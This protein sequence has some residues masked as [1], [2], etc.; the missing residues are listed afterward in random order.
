[1][2]ISASEWEKYYQR[3][4]KLEIGDGFKTTSFPGPNERTFRKKVSEYAIRM[5]KQ[6]TVERIELEECWW[7]FIV[8]RV[9]RDAELP[10]DRL[11]VGSWF[12]VPV[13]TLSF[14]TVRGRVKMF[15]S[16]SERNDKK[17]WQFKVYKHRGNVY[18][19]RVV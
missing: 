18:V 4:S 7:A 1:M 14:D 17:P 5:R 11:K 8:Y 6:F 3:L 16:I 10:F 9:N 19:Q 2:S 13:A 15:E 12:E